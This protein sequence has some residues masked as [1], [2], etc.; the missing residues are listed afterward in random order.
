MSSSTNDPFWQ[1]NTSGDDSPSPAHNRPWPG[2][3]PP[4]QRRFERTFLAHGDT[5][6]FDTLPNL[7]IF[8]GSSEA[9]RVMWVLREVAA[10][11]T[12]VQRPL[13]GTEANA[14]SEHCASSFRY[15]TW[16]LPVT[17]GIALA[18]TISG[19]RTFNFPFY[20]PKMQ[21]FDPFSFPTRRAPLLKGHWA[22]MV[23]HG[24]RFVTYTSVYLVP[25]SAMF[26]SIA[27]TSFQQNARRDP[28]LMRL[29]EDARRRDQ[30]H[31]EEE[32]RRRTSGSNP[33]STVPQNPQQMED[34]AYQ[35][36]PSP[37]VYEQT[38]YASQPS[39]TFERPSPS[40]Q[41]PRSE[42][43]NNAPPAYDS[44]SDDDSNPFDDDDDDA[45][46]VASSARRSGTGTGP[47]TSSGSVWE[48][49]RQQAK[50][51]TADWEKGDSSGQGQGWAQLRQDKTRNPKDATPKTDSYS[52]SG[53]DEERER[54]KYEKEQAQK[55]FD[56]L[57]AADSRD[58]K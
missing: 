44:R 31:L 30:I 33:A 9:A 5:I 22:A 17:L 21:K 45:S 41:P 10:Q 42:T 53:R 43:Q 40:T 19:R 26:F 25:T 46:P 51:G 55:E 2:V 56:A 23:W 54:R 14:V 6:N 38:D 49:M 16:G 27:N 29:I 36:R 37:Q 4:S 3:D 15:A 12:H 7:P 48:R 57:I 58:S 34:G 28:R 18:L 8:F 47:S 32:L 35:D 1:D 52:Y 50:S 11:S 20:Q 24:V 13:T 39:R